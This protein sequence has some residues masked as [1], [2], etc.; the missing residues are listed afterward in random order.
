LLL[1]QIFV[2]G[3]TEI[4]PGLVGHHTFRETIFSLGQLAGQGVG[5]FVQL[6]TPL[7]SRVTKPC[8]GGGEHVVGL[9]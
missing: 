2:P 5:M 3:E 9:I 6:T 7:N 4:V 8:G 1:L